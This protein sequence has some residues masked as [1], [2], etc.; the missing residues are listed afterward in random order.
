[1]SYDAVC[2]S[3]EKKLNEK[4]DHEAYKLKPKHRVYSAHPTMNDFLP[5]CILS[6]RIK[7]KG[8]IKMFTENGII[9]DGDD[10]VT[11]IDTVIMATGYIIKFP[12]L[13]DLVRIEDNRVDL[14]KY[15]IPPTL[16][17]PTLAILGLI[18]PLGPIFPISEM[19]CRWFAQLLLGNVQ[20]PSPSEML[21]DIKFKNQANA[22]RYVNSTRHTIQVDWIPFMDELSSAIGAKPSLLKMAVTDPRLFLACFNGPCLP[23]QYRLQGPFAWSGARDTIL[24]YEKRVF[25]ALN[26]E[27][28]AIAKTEEKGYG[29]VILFVLCISSILVA[30]KQYNILHRNLFPFL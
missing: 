3:V 22:R 27:G 20:L 4:F 7:V 14:Y 10:E 21:K 12:F 25:A 1:M 30:Q 17:H 2:T 6:G 16:N 15:A 18:Q 11:E 13:G 23:Y 8:D 29:K 5:N 26:S 28:K 24:N 9:F 19:Q